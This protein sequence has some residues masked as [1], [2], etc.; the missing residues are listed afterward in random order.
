MAAA[1]EADHTA[2]V[3]KCILTVAAAAS[4]GR[5]SLHEHGQAEPACATSFPLRQIKD[6]LT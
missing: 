3:R 1:G 6:L 4:D 2:P 5:C